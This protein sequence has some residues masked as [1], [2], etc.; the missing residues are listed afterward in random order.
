MSKPRKV[1]VAKD[2]LLERL[3]QNRDQHD[4][5]Y[6][7]ALGGYRSRLVLVLTRMFEAAKRKEDVS[8]KIDLTV[9]EDHLADYDRALQ[10]MEWEQ[11]DSLRL[12]QGEFDRYVMD[13]WSWSKK[14]KAVHASYIVPQNR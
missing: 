13:N 9:P 7:E 1:Q 4:R 11:R 5:E 6:Q 8:H 14:F 12:S 3:K 2:K 10:V